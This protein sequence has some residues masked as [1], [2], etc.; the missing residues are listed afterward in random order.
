VYT[1]VEEIKELRAGVNDEHG[2][3]SLDGNVTVHVA[4]ASAAD[5][6]VFFAL[7]TTATTL[8]ITLEEKKAVYIDYKPPTTA[9]HV[10]T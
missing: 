10:R 2:A 8:T 6:E 3:G 4:V 1:P 7:P 5:I 9:G